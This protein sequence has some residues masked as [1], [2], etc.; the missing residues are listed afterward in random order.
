M[1]WAG[2]AE[3]PRWNFLEGTWSSTHKN[4]GPYLSFKNISHKYM[5]ILGNLE[6]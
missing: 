6:I 4:K 3:I 2:K 1:G 5:F